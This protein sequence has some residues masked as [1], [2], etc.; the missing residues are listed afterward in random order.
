MIGI[1][2]IVVLFYQ[3]F[4]W[5]LNPKYYYN[6]IRF[7]KSGSESLTKNCIKFGSSC[8]SEGQ[9]IFIVHPETNQPY[10]QIDLHDTSFETSNT[11]IIGNVPILKCSKGSRR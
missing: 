2:E 8:T 6:L 7:P 4:V 10:C 9:G 11:R 5:R 3:G 1:I